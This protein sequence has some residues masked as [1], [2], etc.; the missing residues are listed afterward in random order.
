MVW[1]RQQ[2]FSFS[3]EE[4]RAKGK[5]SGRITETEYREASGVVILT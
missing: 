5:M 1:W 4:R 3:A 2:S